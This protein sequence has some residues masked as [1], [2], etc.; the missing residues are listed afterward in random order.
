MNLRAYNF[1][2]NQIEDLEDFQSLT[3]LDLKKFLHPSVRSK[4]DLYRSSGESKYDSFRLSCNT[5]LAL[6]KHLDV[7]L[8][9]KAIR[10][11]FLNFCKSMMRRKPL[12]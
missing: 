4:Y 3:D 5:Y 9:I 12:E 6:A 8:M 7:Y 11:N 10:F 2:T 1:K